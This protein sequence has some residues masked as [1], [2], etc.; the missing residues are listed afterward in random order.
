M[1]L[2]AHPKFH[3]L[4]SSIE[5]LKCNF[6]VAESEK[7]GNFSYLE[8]PNAGVEGLPSALKRGDRIGLEEPI[9]Q[10]RQT[11]SYLRPERSRKM[12]RKKQL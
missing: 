7:T 8:R 5:P 1:R 6:T 4:E 2:N 10:S 11:L 3:R 12:D 9:R